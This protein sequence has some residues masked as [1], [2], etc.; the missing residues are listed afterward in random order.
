M[1]E[2]LMQMHRKQSRLSK[3]VRSQNRANSDEFRT[4]EPH[5]GAPIPRGGWC[6]GQPIIHACGHRI[7]ADVRNPIAIESS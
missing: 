2:T 1:S 5:P 7:S 4:C 3:A 6:E